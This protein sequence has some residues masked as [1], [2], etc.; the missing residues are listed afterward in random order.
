MPIKGPRPVM[1]LEKSAVDQEPPERRILLAEPRAAAIAKDAPQ[2]IDTPK[3]RAGGRQ[4]TIKSIVKC[5]NQAFA[6]SA[7][8]RMSAVSANNSSRRY[9]GFS[10]G[11]SES[12]PTSQQESG[13]A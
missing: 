2:R 7:K 4:N 11:K 10:V 13:L 5:R 12:T 9:R 8:P 6:S 3:A 1:A